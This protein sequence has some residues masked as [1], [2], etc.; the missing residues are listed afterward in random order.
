MAIFCRDWAALKSK[1]TNRTEG[2]KDGAGRVCIYREYNVTHCYTIECSCNLLHHGQ[3]FSRLY[4]AP[5]AHRDYLKDLRSVATGRINGSGKGDTMKVSNRFDR[6]TRN[7]L[8]T[9]DTLSTASDTPEQFQRPCTLVDCQNAHARLHSQQ[10]SHVGTGECGTFVFSKKDESVSPRSPRRPN[11]KCRLNNPYMCQVDSLQPPR[12]SKAFLPPFGFPDVPT[13]TRDTNTRD[14][15]FHSSGSS[16]KHVTSTFHCPWG[17]CPFD[18][19]AVFAGVG[20]A[21]VFALVELSGGP[22]SGH[23]SRL[24]NSVWRDL[25]NLKSWALRCT[26]AMES[27]EELPP[28][29]FARNHTYSSL[30]GDSKEAS[31]RNSNRLPVLDDQGDASSDTTQS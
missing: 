28:D 8:Q 14:R 23:S 18:P 25:S 7:R 5:H 19:P 4:S 21:V 20:R 3:V 15:M 1:T 26:S 13:N 27:G 16:S 2:N 30:F 12:R 29:A 10:F 17:T 22:D 9:D 31:D 6:F 11:V 24:H